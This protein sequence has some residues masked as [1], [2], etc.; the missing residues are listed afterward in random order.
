MLH[1]DGLYDQALLRAAALKHTTNEY[2][3]SGVHH[4]EGGLP[5]RT[6]ANRRRAIRDYSTESRR[7]GVVDFFSGC[8]GTSAGLRA[9]GMD[10]LAGI[11]IDREAANTFTR[12]F[13][14]AQF[15]RADITKLRTAALRSILGSR[16]PLLFSACAPCQP[17]S[18]QRRGR[19]EEDTRVPLLLEFVRFVKYY[20]P[21]YVFIEN[22][23][24]LQTLSADMGPFPEFTRKMTALGYRLDA[25]IIERRRPAH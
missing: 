19:K 16:R 2:N 14:Q 13:P 6:T 23:P 7:I 15:I 22:V 24:G 9:A 4:R 18:K 5:K 12:N 3:A 8:G 21:E 17:F 1:R 25:R 11:D 10:I 20:E